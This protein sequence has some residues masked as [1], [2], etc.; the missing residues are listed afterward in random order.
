MSSSTLPTTPSPAERARL[1][2]AVVRV[3]ETSL[4]AV[5]EPL[6][7]A[8]PAPDVAG[9][10]DVAVVRFR[11]PFAGTMT[12]SVPDPLA[13]ELC[14][15]FLGEAPGPDAEGAISDFAGEMANMSCG[16]W[17]T[18]LEADGCFDLAHP[19]VTRQDGPAPAPDAVVL[20]N[21][22]PVSVAV[23]IEEEP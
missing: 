4:F 12:L 18:V 7:D 17:L 5:A 19:E 13:R 10:W 23:H 15:L 16:A 3:A 6:A 2:D 21:D 9:P 22:W 11:G 20:V 8:T 1:I 14:E